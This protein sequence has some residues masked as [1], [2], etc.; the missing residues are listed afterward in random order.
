MTTEH[1]GKSKVLFYVTLVALVL[2]VIVGFVAGPAAAP[3]G[4]VAKWIIQVLKAV[5]VPLLFVAIVDA[6]AQSHM[7]GRGFGLL[8]GVASFNAIIAVAIGLLLV[9]I[10]EPGRYLASLVNATTALGDQTAPVAGTAFNLQD[11]LVTIIPNSVVEPFLNGSTPAVI[12]MAIAF[13]MA[14]RKLSCNPESGAEA[15]IQLMGAVFKVLITIIEWVVVLVPVA[16]FGAVAKAVGQGGAAIAGGLAVFLVVCLGG[17][18]IH[19]L[20][21]YQGWVL[22][23][24]RMTLRKFWTAARDPATYSFGINSSLAT[25]PMTLSALKRLGVKE[26]AARL[27]ACVGTNFNNDGILLYQ[28]VAALILSQALGMDLSLVQ[29][30]HIV[31]VAIGA[32]IGVAGFPEAGVVAL[33]LVLTAA[34]LPVELVVM[35]MSVDWLIARSRSATN[36][37]GDM[38]VAT[39]IDRFLPDESEAK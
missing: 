17:M 9:N 29:Q 25:M 28:V 31:V 10:F 33:T 1:S 35:L 27:S 8:V 34:G 7:S 22:C 6:L 5:A 4:E 3:L 16:V 15:V 20:I 36:V 37:L 24:P 12:V 26:E 23:H 19:I 11:V 30:F 21:T 18:L 14:L 38:A 32:T 13:G 2:G 39:A